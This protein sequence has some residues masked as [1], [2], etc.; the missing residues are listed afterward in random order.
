MM[1]TNPEQAGFFVVEWSASPAAEVR[2]SP[3]KCLFDR[4]DVD[5]ADTLL[6]FVDP[7]ANNQDCLGWPVRNLLALLYVRMPPAVQ[8]KTFRLLAFRPRNGSESIDD[9]WV[10]D[11]RFR[12]PQN[13]AWP[14]PPPVPECVG[15]ERDPHGRLLP[16]FVNL[17]SSMDPHRLAEASADLNLKLMKWRQAPQLDL[18]V[19][20]SK[21]YLLIGAGTLGCYM[22]R[23]LMVKAIYI[24]IYCVCM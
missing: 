11:I 3:L 1:H 20:S 12:P 15:W 2:L 16:R 14:L 6:A 18:D 10:F 13:A 8:Q 4:A 17:G 22:A 24:Y 23:C 9:S 19:I 7:C 5:W 21:R